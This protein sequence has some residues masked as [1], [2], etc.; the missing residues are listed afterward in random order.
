MEDKKKESF[1]LEEKKRHAGGGYTNKNYNR[2]QTIVE[3]DKI[4]NGIRRTFVSTFQPV[5]ERK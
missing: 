1:L 2:P 3:N 5:R 4:R